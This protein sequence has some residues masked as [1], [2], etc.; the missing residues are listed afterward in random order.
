MK[1]KI[2]IMGG[3]F[4]PIHMGHLMMSEYVRSELDLDEV[5]FVPTGN[6]PHKQIGILEAEKRLE[7]VKIAIA[8]NPHFTVSDLEVQKK[9]ISYSVDTVLELKALHPEDEF[10]FLIGSDLLP[11]L[12]SWKRFDELATEI[13]FVLSIRPGFDTITKEDMV[14]EIADLKED[15]GARVTVIETPLYEISSTQ[16]RQRIR[17]HRSVR[18]LVKQEVISKIEEAGY[19]RK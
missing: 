17:D 7:M 10:Y 16:I 2:G 8:D 15:Y 19:Y 12:K 13:E 1:K 11:Q 3:S 6:P 14:H 4:D 18:Y 9:G 5:L